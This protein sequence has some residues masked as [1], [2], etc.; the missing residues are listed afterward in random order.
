MEK[1]IKEMWDNYYSKGFIGKESYDLIMNKKLKTLKEIIPR[2]YPIGKPELA[3]VR[4]EDIKKEAIKWVKDDLLILD[5]L[6]FDTKESVIA[7]L[8]IRRYMER[9]NILEEDLKPKKEY[10]AREHESYYP[11]F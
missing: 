10:N 6:P 5:E 4:I 2:Q 8:L 9:L 7:D 3:F 1:K 11:S